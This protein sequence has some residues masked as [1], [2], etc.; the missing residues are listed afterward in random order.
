MRIFTH[1]TWLVL[2]LVLILSGTL[3][4]ACG[5][6]DDDGNVGTALSP[7]AAAPTAVVVAPA[8]VAPA[9]PK[10]Q[11]LVMAVTPPT[12]EFTVPRLGG[13]PQAFPV[14]PIY[15]YLIG[16]DPATGKFVPQL[17]TNWSM[18]PDG[19]S[20]R[21]KLRKGVQFQH[22]FGEFTAKDVVFTHEMFIR[23]DSTHGQAPTYADVVGDVEVVNDYEVIFRLT[24]PFAGFLVMISEQQGNMGDQISKA[25]HDA[26]GEPS[27]LNDPLVGTGPYQ[28]VERVQ[29]SYVRYEKVPYKHWRI[30]PDFPEFEYRWLA[31]PST[32]LAALLTEEVHL[33]AIPRDNIAT[34]EE[35]GMTVIQGRVPG[36]RTFIRYYC[37]A[38]QDATKTWPFPDSPLL[39]LRVR[40]AFS[41][42][43]NRD[44]L[45][46]AYFGGTAGR[47]YN[48][49]QNPSREGWN[50]E[51]VTK[52]PEEHGY[53]P[54]ASRALL[55]EA[56]YSPSKPLKTNLFVITETR[57][58]PAS[59]D[60]TEAI[61]GYLEDVGV[62]VKLITSEGGK[63]NAGTK[64]P[65][66]WD[67]HL[68]LDITAS[69]LFIAMRVK[70]SGL[71]ARLAGYAD[72]ELNELY[73]QFRGEMDDKKRDELARQWGNRHYE[74]HA[75]LPLFWIPAEIVVN[76]ATVSDY[77][78]PGSFTGTWSHISNI[79]AAQ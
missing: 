69:D 65:F 9:K 41:K 49:H 50:P 68:N 20:F 8:T 10:V 12:T 22:D 45:N 66:Q 1:G 17:S 59:R 31:E 36:Q 46:T 72:A 79:K 21:F 16:I 6:G 54:A 47:M 55:A 75:S 32:R 24:K 2:L 5:S 76:S 23:E 3:L 29:S 48:A 35:A 73:T 7:A 61:G 63:V 13:Q 71:R 33:A 25:H 78:F 58:I 52:F 56:G 70:N 19:L 14:R 51:W 39:D 57:G 67:N 28:M 38:F 62:E 40:K 11:R 15:E 26:K 30:T 77:V 18:E 74:Q 42:A 4:V 44:E 43:V 60:M 64:P 34:A 37:C 53:D 27:Q